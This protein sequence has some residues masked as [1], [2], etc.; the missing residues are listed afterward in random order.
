MSRVGVVV[1][2]RN[3]SAHLKQGLESVLRECDTMVYVDSGSE[4]NSVAI[5]SALGVAVV[6]LDSTSPFSAARAR[7]AGFDYLTRM[8]DRL[9]FIQFVDGDCELVDGWLGRA[10]RVLI[11][12][13]D[14]A[15]V[16]GRRREKFPEASVYNALCEVEWDTPSGEAKASGGD[17]M[18]RVRGF[19][20]VGGFDPQ[21]AWGDDPELCLRLRERGWKIVRIDAEM[22]RHDAELL[23]WHQWWRRA[24]LAGQA[25]AQVTWMHG[26]QPEHYWVRESASIGFW[27][28]VLPVLAL[29]FAPKSRAYS[30]WLLLGYPLLAAR[31]F[32]H[33]RRRN[34]SDERA[35]LYALFTVIGKFANLQGALQFLKHKL[36]SIGARTAGKKSMFLNASDREVSR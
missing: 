23:Y 2:G 21:V 29:A 12:R 17:M 27:G 13:N 36:Y 18:V 3:E 32:L 8:D 30:L 10:L 20:Q 14:V 6:R 19:T 9:E 26:R 28:L 7:N 35:L 4:D 31:I 22:T 15:V 24:T 11:D 33:T 16:C 34:V 25:Y 1:I 5:A